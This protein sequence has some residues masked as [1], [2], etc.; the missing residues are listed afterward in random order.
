MAKKRKYTK[1]RDFHFTRKVLILIGILLAS[2]AYL[3]FQK[4]EKKAEVFLHRPRVEQDLIARTEAFVKNHPF[5]KEKIGIYIY[6]LTA[7]EELYAKN[8]E[9]LLP[10]ASCTKLV[11][12]IASMARF[13]LDFQLKDSLFYQGTIRET[14]LY[15]NLCLK[16]D[17]DPMEREFTNLLRELKQLGI[18]HI[19][20]EIKLQ[21][22]LKDA[23]K[24]HPSWSKRDMHVGSLPV[25]F[26]GQDAIRVEIRKELRELGIQIHEETPTITETYHKTFVAAEYHTLKEILMPVLKFSSNIHAQCLWTSLNGQYCRLVPD[27]DFRQDYLMDFIGKELR[28]PAYRYTLS[29]ACGLSPENRVTPKFLTDIL[30]WAWIREDMREYLLQ[31]L[32]VSGNLGAE[33][34]GSLHWRMENSPAK[35]RVFAK[36]GT[37]NRLG[38]TSLSGYL[39]TKN[40]HWL[41]FSIMNRDMTVDES[42]PYQDKLCIELCR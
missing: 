30:R 19:L 33:K 40:D 25:I 34:S 5:P 22:P 35:G 29:D 6:D 31:A 4:G 11:T 13:G 7:D 24:F 42:R 8:E 9:Q 12:A 17:A 23:M 32:P 20:G 41:V 38:V 3:M 14:T 16:V 18:Q 1:I 21:T 37:L 15:G 10:P 36:T 2:G 39:R 27:Q 26:Q 28:Q